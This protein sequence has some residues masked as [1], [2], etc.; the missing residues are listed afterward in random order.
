MDQEDIEKAPC[1][2]CGHHTSHTIIATRTIEE[3]PND[4]PGASGFWTNIYTMLECCG[5]QVVSLRYDR[6]DEEENQTKTFYYPPRVARHLPSW[7]HRIPTHLFGLVTEIYVALA[8][9]SVRLAMMGARSL[10]DMMV[11]EKIGDMG[12][13]RAK[14]QALQD[15]GFIGQS[16]REQLESAFDAGS[17]A[18]H[19]GYIPSVRVVNQV[20]D[21]VEH[22]LQSVYVLS[23]AAREVKRETPRRR[24]RKR[25]VV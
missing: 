13:F 10:I 23:D 20:M 8:A 16:Q 22:L 4:Y 19:R 7:G 24:R 18:V 1:N 12:P 11:V 2:T 9:Q 21:I 15:R 3:S 6:K 25:P 17:A 14:L 5:C